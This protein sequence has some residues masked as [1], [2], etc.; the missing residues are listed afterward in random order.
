[1]SEKTP[2]NKGNYD[3]ETPE[4]LALFEKY[5]ALG[6]EEEYQAYR[7][8]WVEYAKN[9][10]VSEYPLLVDIELSTVCNL[11]CPMCY[12]ITEEFK[13]S[14][15]KQFMD[16]ALF[17]KI[18]DEI[19]GKVPAVQKDLAAVRSFNSHQ[20]LGNGGLAASVGA[21]DH[22]HF[23]IFHGKAHVIRQPALCSVFHDLIGQVLYFKHVYH[24]Q[25]S[26]VNSV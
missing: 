25:F 20:A 12:T 21:G 16:W 22:K 8:N 19:G 18:V 9:Q 6:W 2:I 5:R 3:M 26:M 4:R 15:S 14:V 23:P 11:H 1:M 24:L 17:Q 13:K 7:R 10:C